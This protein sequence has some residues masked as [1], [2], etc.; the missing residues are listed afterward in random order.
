MYPRVVL[1]HPPDRIHGQ[2]AE[3][4]EDA[5]HSLVESLLSG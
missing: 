1:N 5:A 4:Q 3:K 2:D